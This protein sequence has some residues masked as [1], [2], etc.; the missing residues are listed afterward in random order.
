MVLCSAPSLL[1]YPVAARYQSCYPNG[2]GGDQ[3]PTA[4]S[5]TTAKPTT[6][7]ELDNAERFMLITYLPVKT[8][9]FRMKGKEIILGIF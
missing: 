8:V 1:N 2:S 4:S 7:K 3:H 6:L 5:S 9:R